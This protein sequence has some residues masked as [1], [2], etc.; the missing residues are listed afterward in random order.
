WGVVNL[1]ENGGLIDYRNNWCASQLARDGATGELIWAYNMTPADNWDL[2]EP[3][4]NPLVDIEIGGELRETAIKAARNGA[5]Y[6]WARAA[7]ELVTQPRDFRYVDFRTGVDMETGRALYDIDKWN[8][9]NVEDRRRYTDVDPGRNA[10]GTT[11]NDY[12]GTEVHWCPGIQ[13]RN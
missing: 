8:F 6:V 3:I 4:M 5:F 7:G 10:D 1:D 11:V 9:T 13:S 2:D 12:T